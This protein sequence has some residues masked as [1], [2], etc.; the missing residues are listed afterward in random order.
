MIEDPDAFG[1]ANARFHQRLVAL[2]GNQTL[3]V[4]AE[5]LDEIVTRGVTAASKRGP[6]TESLAVRRRGIRSQR[7]LAEL[8]EAG[9]ATAAEEHWRTHMTAVGRVMLGREAT[10]VVDL[11]HHL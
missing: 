10:A 2:A 1:V 4:M 8:V 7:R 11:V 3:S 6:R 9:D 5:M